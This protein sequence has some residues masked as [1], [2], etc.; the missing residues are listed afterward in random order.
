LTLNVGKLV[1]LGPVDRIPIV[2][3]KSALM[4]LIIDQYWRQVVTLL[5]KVGCLG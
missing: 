2:V 1:L 3:D 4:R 5:V